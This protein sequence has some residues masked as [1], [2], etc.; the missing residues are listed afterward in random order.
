M[1]KTKLL[2]FLDLYK[3]HYFRKGDYV[4]S[5]LINELISLLE[6]DNIDNLIKELVDLKT[7]RS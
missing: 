2:K 3:N 6:R 1:K 5:A 4:E 7:R